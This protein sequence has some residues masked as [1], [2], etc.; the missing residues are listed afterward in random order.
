M[1]AFLLRVVRIL[2][3]LGV[4]FP[5]MPAQALALRFHPSLG[6]R[7]PRA[8][9]R[10]CCRIL[11]F[12][13]EVFGTPSD[14]KPTLFVGNHISYLD[15]LVFGA[16]VPASFVA[17]AEVRGWPLFGWL[18]RLQ[19]T[20]FVDRQVRSTHKQRDA[21]AERL[22]EGG[23]LILFPEG[24]SGD[25]N[26]VLPFK[27]SLFSV[28]AFEDAQG[29]L[30]VQ[31]VSVAYVKLDGMPMGRGFRPFFAWYGDMEMAPHLW[32]VLGLG[33]ATI[34]VEFH[35]P[36]T[37]AE[38]R[39]R[40]ALAQHCETVIAQGVAAALSGRRPAESVADPAPPIPA[41]GEPVSAPEA[42]SLS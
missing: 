14:R 31:P 10:I 8:Y 15:I 25:G 12:R 7:L 26:R 39:S 33:S 40:K 19:K 5:L 35:A 38:F 4:T 23:S 6:D 22:A 2:L 17:K 16:V 9:H 20:V 30:T 3:Y 27:S 11:G 36:V 21:I 34:R 24:T 1:G 28:A 37:L 41:A 42:A 29:P 18:A 13:L 32:T